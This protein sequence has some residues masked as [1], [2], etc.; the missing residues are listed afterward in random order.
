M[1]QVSMKRDKPAELK[2]L[3]D[4][5]KTV[6]VAEQ[7]CLV[8]WE[9]FVNIDVLELLKNRHTKR[10]ECFSSSP[11]LSLSLSFFLQPHHAG[12]GRLHS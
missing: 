12:V 7:M 11:L 10:G 4:P 3:V 9:I 1:C 5:T 2:A 6:E 8:D